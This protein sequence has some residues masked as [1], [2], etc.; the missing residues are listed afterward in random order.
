M[1][2]G[3]NV[4]LV[5]S[6]SW[7]VTACGNSLSTVGGSSSSSDVGGGSSASS[8]STGDAGA[9]GS[10]VVCHP[11]KN[12]PLIQDCP[13]DAQCECNPTKTTDQA[14][15]DT[16]TKQD[17]HLCPADANKC[18]PGHNQCGYDLPKGEDYILPDSECLE[19][20]DGDTWAGDT[21]VK[22]VYNANGQHEIRFGLLEPS[23]LYFNGFLIH[24]R[25]LLWSNANQ[26]SYEWA[27]GYFNGDCKQITINYYSPLDGGSEQIPGHTTTF[28][29][30]NP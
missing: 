8:T 19:Y 18:S 22:A 16:W 24:G 3:L 4:F 12:D 28:S 27:E 14:W 7:F 13:S 11:S 1:Q 6:L 26:T 17:I 21:V 5:L 20:V 25:K 30:T 29:W 10:D 2:R 23:I 9:T 15:C